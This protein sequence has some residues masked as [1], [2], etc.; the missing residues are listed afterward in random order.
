MSYQTLR[1]KQVDIVSRLKRIPWL[2][3][4][5]FPQQQ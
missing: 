4:S 3:P 2:Y 1:V 5:L